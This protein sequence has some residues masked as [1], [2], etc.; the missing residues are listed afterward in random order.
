MKK[1]DIQSLA[2][3]LLAAISVCHSGCRAIRSIRQNDDSIAGRRMSRQG[4]QALRDGNWDSAEQL[5]NNALA[6]SDT[7]DRAHRGLAESLWQRDDR[8]G[9]I[10]HM[11]QAV[12][13]SAGEPKLIERL[14]RMYL[15]VGRLDD[16]FRQCMIALEADRDSAAVWGL[17]G[18]CLFQQGRLDE[19]LAAYHRALA[20]QPDFVTVQLQAAEVYRS[21]GRYDRLLATLD[22]LQENAIDDRVPSRALMLRGIAMQQL[23]QGQEAMRCF[24]QAAA[25]DPKSAEPHLMIA[26]LCLDGDDVELARSAV[27]LAKGLDPEAVQRGRW[28]EQL[29][30]H[31]Q[32]IAARVA[33]GTEP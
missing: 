14:G 32:R 21:Q 27:E 17:R 12:R 7:D 33:D 25:I 9:A 11:E 29:D 2:L 19:A 28:I 20:I 13:L 16:A 3:S 10:K 15:E 4:I 8:A 18:D 24:Q 23:R 26:S 31:Q 1:T 22:R 6:R 30:H 5:F